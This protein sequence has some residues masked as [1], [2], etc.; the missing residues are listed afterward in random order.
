[1]VPSVS[2]QVTVILPPHDDGM[3]LPGVSAVSIVPQPPPDVTPAI[4]FAN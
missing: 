2:V 4:Q 3:A 1:V